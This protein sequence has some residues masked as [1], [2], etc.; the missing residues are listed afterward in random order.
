M[1]DSINK[2]NKGKIFHIFSEMQLTKS[3][4]VKALKYYFSA[5]KHGR[6]F[7]HR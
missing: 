4:K 3:I 1:H 2:Q 7:S 6:T 5:I